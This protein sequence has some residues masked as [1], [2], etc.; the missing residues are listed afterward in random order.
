MNTIL[1]EITPTNKHELNILM[2]RIINLIENSDKIKE[3][4]N[5]VIIN[6]KVRARD[7]Y[8]C[9]F[10]GKNVLEVNSS[11]TI[12]HLIPARYG[13]KTEEKNLITICMFCHQ[14]LEKYIKIVEKE[15]IK[16]TLNYV[17]D[18]LKWKI[19]K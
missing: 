9:C 3:D 1:K 17:R 5:K 12:H 6:P 13:G 14:R 7:N 15:A 11:N 4:E 8:K 16:K 18:L 10:C 19:Q 2:N